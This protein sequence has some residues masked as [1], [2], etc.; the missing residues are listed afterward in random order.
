MIIDKP[1]DKASPHNEDMNIYEHMNILISQK[2]RYVYTRYKKIPWCFIT[3]SNLI[4][5]CKD[6]VGIQ[7]IQ[8]K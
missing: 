8:N 6:D 1:E 5:R 7:N 4:N 2:T 3:L